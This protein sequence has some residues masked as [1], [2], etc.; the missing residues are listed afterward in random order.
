AITG[1]TAK[2]RSISVIS[3]CL[4]RNANFAIAHAAARPNITLHGTAMAAAINVSLIAWAAAGS[5]MAAKYTS[6]PRANASVKTATSGNTRN[7]LRNSSAVVI[8]ATRTANGSVVALFETTPVSDPAPALISTSGPLVAPVLEQIDQQQQQERK[9]QHDAAERGGAG[10]VVLFETGHD[11]QR[12]DFGFVRHV[13]ADK[14]HRA[15]FADGARE[16]QCITRQQCRQQRRQ[17]H[18]PTGL[19]PC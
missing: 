12:R 18:T 1:D 4:P 11:Q 14:D 6:R 10:V 9:N 8:R 17:Q 13:A 16:R 3:S 5:V 2:G 19:Q 7:R 15:V